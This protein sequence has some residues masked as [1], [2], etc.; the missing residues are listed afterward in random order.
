MPRA[1]MPRAEWVPVPDQEMMTV[2]K[3]LGVGRELY[4]S[5]GVGPKTG[6]IFFVFERRRNNHD[7]QLMLHLFAPFLSHRGILSFKLPY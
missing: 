5:L 4:L 1:W 6:A 2:S 3:S 7:S